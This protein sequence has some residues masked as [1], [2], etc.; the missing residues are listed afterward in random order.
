MKLSIFLLCKVHPNMVMHH[1]Q[2]IFMIY[3]MDQ[4]ALKETIFKNLSKLL[5]TPLGLYLDE[6]L[7]F[8]QCKNLKTNKGIGIIQGFRIP[9]PES[10]F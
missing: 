1:E 2:C 7:S 10:P 6:K 8:Y 5:K 9:F 4:L 3:V